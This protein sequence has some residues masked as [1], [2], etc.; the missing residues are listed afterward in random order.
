MQPIFV[1]VLLCCPFALSRDAALVYTEITVPGS[2]GT[3]AI[4]INN[5][6]D[7]VGSYVAGGQTHGFLL[8]SGQYTTISFPGAQST[9]ASSI[10]DEGDV[11]GFYTDASGRTQFMDSSETAVGSCCSTYP[12]APKP[13]AFNAFNAITTAIELNDKDHVVRTI[14]IPA[15]KR[16]KGS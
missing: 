16:L 9:T 15:S 7:V 1:V 8:R 11:L 4:G 13:R 6:G 5:V 3:Q 12:T 14:S 2:T 10:N